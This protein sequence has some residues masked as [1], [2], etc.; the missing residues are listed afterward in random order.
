MYSIWVKDKFHDVKSVKLVWHMLAF[1][2]EVTSERTDKQLEKLQ[3]DVIKLIKEIETATK[4]N[5]FPTC[6]SAL[7]D[8]CGFKSKCPSF[9]HQIEL[10]KKAEESIKKFKDDDGLKLVDEFS[11]IKAKTLELEKKQEQ[12]KAELIEFAKQK[13]IDTIYGSNMKANIREFDK[14]VLP[15]DEAEKKKFIDL[16][17]SKGYWEECSMICYSRVQSKAVKQ[18]FHPDLLEKVR[19]EKDK[20]ISLSRRKEGE[21]E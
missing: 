5:K 10:D 21:G 17:K 8:Y 12:L 19:L 11:E 4:E 2:K 14:L 1:N 6:T 15:E 13:K 3:E 7:C 16:L 9:K 18:E 20:R